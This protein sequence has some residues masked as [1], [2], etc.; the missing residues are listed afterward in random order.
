MSD[1]IASLEAIVGV[2]HVLSGD[3]AREKYDH[4]W[5][6]Q[7]KGRSQAVVRPAST[8]EV[9][10]ILS[11]A[12]TAKVPVIPMGGNTGLTGAT[13]AVPDLNA[14]I[15]TVERMNRILEIKPQ[16]HVIR[17]EAGAILDDIRAAAEAEDLCFPLVFGAR[18]SCR[19]G[20]NLA[21]NA[22][23]SNVLKYGN[24]RDLCLG[25][26]VVLADGRV[27]NLMSELHKDNTGYDLKN[28]FIGAEG[29]LG[30]ITAA[31]L[32]LVPLPVEYATAMIAMDH[33]E[34]ALGL[35]NT[36]DRLSGGAVE[37]FEFMPKSYCDLLPSA[38]PNLQ[39][40]FDPVPEVTILVE[41]GA[42]SERDRR[43]LTEM[44]ENALMGL[45]QE[46]RVTDA[47]VAQNESQRAEMWLR[48][49][50]TFEVAGQKGRTLDTD[51]ALPLEKLPLFLSRANAE[52]A[53]AAPGSEPIYIAH[54]GDGNVHYSLW[55]DNH[56]PASHDRIVEV[57]ED[58]VDDLGGSF[59]AEHGIG[60]MKLPTMARRK[61]PVALEVMRG[62]KRQL[63]PNAIMNPGKL[64]P[65][66][67]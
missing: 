45:I 3:A 63:D 66:E 33:V 43:F 49:E 23:G 44:L 50:S 11:L 51:V 29:T 47:V 65:D 15:L 18:G 26:E 39:P 12:N 37:A 67:T 24:T 17:V 1:F 38:L 6:P 53:Q 28:L 40:V 10:R 22:G 46:G 31:V 20:G 16:S 41:L 32:K 55:M 7:Y 52:T 34:D 54:L 5:L 36:L 57:I 2:D 27:M 21:T 59:S 58:I 60:L 64:L 25:L 4:G 61:D 30:V 8:D 42:T 19:I 13:M 56:D 35:L 62:I 9:S 48:R 14:I